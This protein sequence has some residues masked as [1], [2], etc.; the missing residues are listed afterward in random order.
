MSDNDMIQE[1]Q[2]NVFLAVNA[3]RMPLAVK[4][5]VLENALLKISSAMKDQREAADSA[6]AQ[7]GGES[8]ENN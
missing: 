2:N 4:A 7:P 3:S 5:L 8:Y 1:L 6:A